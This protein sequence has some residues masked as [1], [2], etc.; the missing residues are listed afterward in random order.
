MQQVLQRTR[1]VL[2]HQRNQTPTDHRHEL[3]VYLGQ[4]PSILQLV[5]G[6][7]LGLELRKHAP[8]HLLKLQQRHLLL[9]GLK[10]WRPAQRSRLPGGP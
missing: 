7:A 1:S 6:E 9:V 10:A 3:A 8:L 4:H 2:V 5:P